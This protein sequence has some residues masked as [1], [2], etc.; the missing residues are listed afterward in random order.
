MKYSSLI[1]IALCLGLSACAGWSKKKCEST[2]WEQ[3]GYSEGSKGVA[4]NS[5]SYSATCSKK[6]AQININGYNNGHSKGMKVFCS[7]DA[8][9]NVGVAN[10]ELNTSCQRFD[11]YMKG[12]S[13]GMKVFC[14]E[15]NGYETAIEG[16]E[17]V[18]KCLRYKAYANAYKNGQKQFCS[19]KNGLRLG[20]K[21]KPFPEK[22]ERSGRAFERSFNRGRV[23][24]LEI[25]F[26]EKQDEGVSVKSDYERARDDLQDMQFELGRLPRY[27][28]DEG[29]LSRK[30]SL[31]SRI[32]NTRRERDRLR[33]TVDANEKDLA[34]I[35]Q[36]IV[37]L[38]KRI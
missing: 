5:G 6:G 28:S 34:E 24:F 36:E 38:K 8:G 29:I 27:S 22:C 16:E 3:L 20:E 11:T 21:G 2:N 30:R 33:E 4:N 9:K 1:S 18:N 12:Y 26:R 13:A 35:K 15:K 7:F 25:T 32:I 17:A 23:K 19:Q 37:Y 31:D 14:S 10:G